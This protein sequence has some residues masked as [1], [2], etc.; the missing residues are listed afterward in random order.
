VPGMAIPLPETAIP[1]P[2]KPLPLP[3]KGLPLARM[4]LPLPG[5][6][7][8]PPKAE[9]AD[10][11]TVPA[12][13][14]GPIDWQRAGSV[15][16]MAGALASEGGV[17]PKAGRLAS[18]EVAWAEAGGDGWRLRDRHRGIQTGL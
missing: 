5:G 11:S 18:T 7:V 1:L 17:W 13:R 6:G 15:E 14:L 3:E 2:R 16:A 12:L 9:C 4:A 10:A 8:P